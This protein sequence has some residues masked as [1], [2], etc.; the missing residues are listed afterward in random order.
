MSSA[1]PE[2]KQFKLALIQLGSPSDPTQNPTET[3]IKH[4]NLNHAKDMIN[5]AA[6]NVN[7][8][9]D[10]VVLPVRRAS[11]CSTLSAS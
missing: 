3:D 1:P 5:R 11:S 10:L 2:F 9:P 6:K 4:A 7:G 8:K